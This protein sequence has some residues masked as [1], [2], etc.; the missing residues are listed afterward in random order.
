VDMKWL[1]NIGL[2]HIAF[3]CWLLAQILVHD[4]TWP[5]RAANHSLKLNTPRA[6]CHGREW[7]SL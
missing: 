6:R 5:G 3:G 2:G 7:S 1:G 4:T